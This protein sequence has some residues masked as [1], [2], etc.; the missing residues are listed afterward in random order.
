MRLLQVSDESYDMKRDGQIERQ[1]DNL[2]D[3]EVIITSSVLIIIAHRT[4][5]FSKKGDLESMVKTF[6]LTQ[7]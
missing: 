4:S 5:G 7:G 6:H 2:K 1:T 3:D